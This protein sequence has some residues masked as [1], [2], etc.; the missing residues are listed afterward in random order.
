MEEGIEGINS[1][2]K[3]KIK[4]KG[5]KDSSKNLCLTSHNCVIDPSLVAREV[6]T[7]TLL[8]EHIATHMNIVFSW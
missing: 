4:E 5:K 7:Y 3:N 1:D 6:R 8:I 2:G